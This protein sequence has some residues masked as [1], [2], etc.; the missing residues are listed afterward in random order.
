MSIVYQ[1]YAYRYVYHMYAYMQMLCEQYVHIVYVV[2]SC[3]YACV[4]VCMAV[5]ICIC[6][7]RNLYIWHMLCMFVNS[8]HCVSVC[9][10]C[11]C[12]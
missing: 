5:W 3:I 7:V 12:A 4:L 1:M 11:I 8:T 10:C 2:C 9:L 6:H